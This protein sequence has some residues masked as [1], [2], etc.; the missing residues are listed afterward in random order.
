MT[1]RLAARQVASW[2]GP[3]LQDGWVGLEGGVVTEVGAG[4][5]RPGGVLDLGDVV[6]APGF[7]DLQVNGIGDVDLIDA[8]PDGWAAVG[9]T[10]ARHGTTA[11]CPT[12]VT[13]P[14]D[15]YAPALRRAQDAQRAADDSEDQARILG[16]HLEGPFLGARPGAHRSDL[17]RVVDVAWLQTLLAD[18]PGIVRIVTLAPEADPGFDAV[19][20]LSDAGITVALGHS[21]ATLDEAL[22]ARDAGASVVT[23][24]FNAM[25]PLHHREPGLVGA[26]LGDDNGLTPTVIADLVHVHP[27][28]LDIVAS[29]EPAVV[30]DS[31]ATTPPLVARDGAAWLPDG[32][33]AGA[34]TLLDGAV[35]NLVH[36]A[37]WSVDEALDAVTWVPANL[38]SSPPERGALVVGMPAD[39]VALD[40]ETLAVQ[41]VWIGGREVAV[42]EG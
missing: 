39:L 11:Y 30:S 19:R 40:P 13:A 22:A 8:S 26:A 10:L 14:L 1:L 41:R 31:V 7:V 34:T 4:D 25:P 12:F 27:H 15:A 37:G 38:L 42:G 23:H 29:S 17:L 2:N 21:T 33:L 20:S 28:V 9:R 18:V 35:A 16:V 36:A 3:S 32:T 5:T 6:L 24:L